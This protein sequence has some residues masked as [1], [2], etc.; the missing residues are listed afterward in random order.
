MHSCR[1][2]FDASLGYMDLC[3]GNF[4]PLESVPSF[5]SW[6]LCRVAKRSLNFHNSL[7]LS[8][9]SV[10]TLH[11]WMKKCHF[12]TL[13]Y[14]MV[15]G[16]HLLFS[17]TCLCTL[18]RLKSGITLRRLIERSWGHSTL[19][20]QICADLQNKLAK[21]W[22]QHSCM[23]RITIGPHLISTP[24]D[25]AESLKRGGYSKWLGIFLRQNSNCSW[26][27]HLSVAAVSCLRET[28]PKWRQECF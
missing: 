26:K 16:P 12:M 20:H 22:G 6:D 5:A 4:C 28:R 17:Y 3:K 1:L 27:L 13:S 15:I 14:H 8:E 9:V 2:G 25:G 10:Q 24:I 7:A 21:R 23:K 11:S 19:L 18:Y